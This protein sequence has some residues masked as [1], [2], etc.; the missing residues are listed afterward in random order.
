MNPIDETHHLLKIVDA[1]QRTA[2]ASYNLSYGWSEIVEC[3]T[4]NEIFDE[5]RLIGTRKG[6]VVTEEE[7]L[8]HFA[9]VAKIRSEHCREIESTIW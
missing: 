1:V 3:W 7:A 4:R 5:L 2:K 6:K 8:E 9:F